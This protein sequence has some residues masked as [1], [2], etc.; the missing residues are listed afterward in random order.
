MTDTP[1][2]PTTYIEYDGRRAV[3]VERP[4]IAETPWVVYVDRRELLTM[5]CTPTRLHCLAL[6]FLLSEGIIGALDDVWQLRVFTG[7][8]RVYVYFPEAGLNEELHQR[9]C[10]EAVGSIDVRLRRPPPLRPEKRILTSGCGGGVTFDTLLGQ[11][12]PLA[13]RLR[14]SAPLLCEL[15]GHMQEHANLYNQSR[16]VHTS[17]LYDPLTGAQLVMAE[18][19]GRHNTLDKI[20]GECLLGDIPTT[21]RLLF[22]SGR[23]STEM[24]GKAYK[25]GVPIVVSR[26]SPTMTSLRLAEA[27]NMTLVGYVRSQRL[28]VYTGAERIDFGPSNNMLDA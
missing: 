2:I 28:R 18:D 27:W 9:T 13:S 26:T 14:V 6:G 4:V 7:E 8:N 3:V 10:E 15:M 17:A 19:V 11:R 5:M 24:I 22:T 25:M 16:G 20:R 21:D 23:I 1:I 12:A